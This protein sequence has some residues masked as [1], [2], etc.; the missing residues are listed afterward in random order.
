[1]SLKIVILGAHAPRGAGLPGCISASH[2]QC[3]SGQP[4]LL[5]LQLV[6]DRSKSEA[7]ISSKMTINRVKIK[8]SCVPP[9]LA[10][11]GVSIR[12]RPPSRPRNPGTPQPGVFERAQTKQTDAGRAHSVAR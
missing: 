10:H 12:G 1:M 11:R 9:A 4:I 7:V 3:A 6:L 2:L 8:N 5:L